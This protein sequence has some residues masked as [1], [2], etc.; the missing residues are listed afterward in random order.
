MCVWVYVMERTCV[1][2]RQTDVTDRNIAL[3]QLLLEAILLKSG[4]LH[5][6]R[7]N[8]TQGIPEVKKAPER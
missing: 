4:K 6:N 3:L 1:R 2:V 8:I 7:Q 5:E